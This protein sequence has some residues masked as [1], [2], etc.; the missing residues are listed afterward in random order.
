MAK[1]FL[2]LCIMLF[3]A[4]SLLSPRVMNR[5]C[6]D[7]EKKFTPCYLKVLHKKLC[8]VNGTVYRTFEQVRDA[9]DLCKAQLC[10]GDCD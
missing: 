4:I 1:Q 9:E 3:G 5:C 7:C 8:N 2:A 10:H 6:L